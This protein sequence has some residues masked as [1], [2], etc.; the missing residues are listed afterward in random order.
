MMGLENKG[1][2]CPRCQKF[3][4]NYVEECP[5]CGLRNPAKKRLLYKVAGLKKV[6]FVRGIITLNVVFFILSYL[7][8]FLIPGLSSTGGRST[9][10]ILPSPSS[11]T[12]YLMGWAGPKQILSGDWWLLITAIF[13]HG[14]LLHIFFNMMWV[15]DLGPITETVFS[16]DKMFLIYILSGVVGNLT[17]VFWPLF[18]ILVFNNQAM[19]SPVIGASGAVFG[20][21]GAII[22]FGRKQGGIAG[23]RIVRQFGL[24]AIILIGMGFVIE[25][26]SNAAHIG[27]FLSGL[28]IGFI[29]NTRDSPKQAKFFSLLSTIILV[30]TIFSFFR[31]WIKILPLFG[32]P[33]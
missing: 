27:G 8:P 1:I 20:L 28:I 5:S 30:A 7:L 15:R 25:G 11:H 16:P 13:L 31:V 10:G 22:A 32:F 12:L 26:I 24:W 9:L 29:L 3:I 21:M 23:Q 6:G 33:N 14:G 18:Q 17:A 19:L 2:L 4:S